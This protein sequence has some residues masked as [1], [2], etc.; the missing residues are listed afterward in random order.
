MFKK[1]ICLQYKKMKDYQIVENDIG[2]EKL[3]DFIWVTP[4]ELKKVV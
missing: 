2:K 1:Q 4:E 3:L